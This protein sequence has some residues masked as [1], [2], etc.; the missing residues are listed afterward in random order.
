MKTFHQVVS[1]ACTKIHICARYAELCVLHPRLSSRLCWRSW[2]DQRTENICHHF[3][4]FQRF[5]QEND[6]VLSTLRL[7]TPVELRDVQ[8]CWWKPSSEKIS[9]R[10]SISRNQTSLLFRKW[11]VQ[12]GEESIFWYSPAQKSY[13]IWMESFGLRSVSMRRKNFFEPNVWIQRVWTNSSGN[14]I[15]SDEANWFVDQSSDERSEY[16]I[17]LIE[18]QLNGVDPNVKEQW[19]EVGDMNTKINMRH[20]KENKVWDQSH[21]EP[22]IIAM[23]TMLFH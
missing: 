5:L 2:L 13:L 20:V 17:K 3:D 18:M 6:P 7:L 4:L 23:C 11:E 16:L 21:I 9:N 1:E 12:H 19:R 10:S 22:S 15:D 8:E 14:R